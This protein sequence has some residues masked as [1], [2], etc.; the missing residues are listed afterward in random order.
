MATAGTANGVGALVATPVAGLGVAAF[1]VRTTAVAM[2]FGLV[3]AGIAGMR[4]AQSSEKS[5][6]S[7]AASAG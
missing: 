5:P 4:W 6:S 2:A 7:A 3:L 1:G